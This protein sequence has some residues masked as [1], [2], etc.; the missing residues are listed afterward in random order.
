VTANITIN[1]TPSA[2]TV[3]VVNNC[4]AT[5]TLTASNYTGS[6]LWNTGA[7]TA[8]IT[9]NTTGTYTVKQTANGCTSAAGSGTATPKTAP[10]APTVSVANS[11]GSSTLTA[12]N[13]TG[14]LLWST[15]ATMQ[16][17][18]VT[19]AGTYTVTQT[20]NGCTSAAGSGTAT[21]GT[22]PSTPTVSVV[23]NCGS[24][25][26][27]AS[28]YTGTL[29]WS[30]GATTQSITVTTAG[31]YTVTQ[32]VTGCISAAGSGTATPGTTPTLSS[33]LT[34]PDVCSNTLFSYHP[35]SATAGTSFN[36]VRQ[37][38]NGISNKQASGKDDINET[39][40][41]TTASPVKV[42]YQYT[43]KTNTCQNTQYV[44]VWVR[45]TPVI[46]TQ[47]LSQTVSAGSN[48]TFTVAAAGLVTG[49]Q[50]QV[51]STSKNS[52]WTNV[53]IGTNYSVTVSSDM[54]SSTLT[55]LKTSNGLN[56]NKYRCIV[57]GQCGQIISNEATLGVNAK[58][59][60]S[61]T[62]ARQTETIIPEE[63]FNVKAFPNP[64]LVDF[65]LKIETSNLQDNVNLKVYDINGRVVKILKGA[66]GETFR[67]GSD[68]TQG[69]Y[70]LEVIQGAKRQT[71]RLI[72][73]VD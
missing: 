27:T 66:P 13:Y 59:Q 51:L 28:N 18:T 64:S 5:S 31:T 57:T 55:V 14:T 36:W 61:T 32:K 16:S 10:T 24:S 35:T 60:T 71:L 63:K 56:G 49:Y 1:T 26:L 65:T 70:L 40:I 6:L 48:A 47:P 25:T 50:W 43:L 67:F 7:T 8:T 37:A 23:N 39:L 12:S 4:N 54:S 53:V 9:V 11:C 42:T 38:V 34:P 21:P 22:T 46:Q 69:V 15:G 33:T 20:V 41:N 2:P 30:T 44:V 17:I 68:F 72:K 19:T 45:P 62:S 58:N 3:I 52:T 73:M 29:L